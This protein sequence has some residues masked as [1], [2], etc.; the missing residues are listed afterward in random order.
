MFKSIRMN[1]YRIEDTKE[2]YGFVQYSVVIT[3]DLF[4]PY[5]V[6]DVIIWLILI[7]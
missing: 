2:L 3:S 1:G 4:Y 6:I 5:K 7:Q